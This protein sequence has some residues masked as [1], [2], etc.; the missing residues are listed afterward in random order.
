MQTVTVRVEGMTCAHCQMAVAKA[1]RS[2]EGVSTAEVDLAR[3]EATIT[4]D[5]AKA[6][7]A[8][9]AEAVADA[10]YRLLRQ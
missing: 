10:G 6:D 2:V 5:P 7:W 4:F 1:L 9:L 3:G 8:R